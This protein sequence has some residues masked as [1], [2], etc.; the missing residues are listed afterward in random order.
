MHRRKATAPICATSPAAD[1]L[2]GLSVL[3]DL[4]DGL[5]LDARLTFPDAAKA[6]TFGDAV[7]PLLSEMKPMLA[8][9]G[10]PEAAID[11]VKPKQEDG[12]VSLHM[13]VD[14]ASFPKVVEAFG[15]MA[16]E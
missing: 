2:Q 12:L 11:A 13:A 7:G 8:G 10:L 16:A 9:F 4:S 5:K 3:A 6:K 14:A 15:K 1:E